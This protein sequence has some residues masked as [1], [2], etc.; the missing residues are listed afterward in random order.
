MIYSPTICD[1]RLTKFGLPAIKDLYPIPD[2]GQEGSCSWKAIIQLNLI[3]NVLTVLNVL[4][5]EATTACPPSSIALPLLSDHVL[6]PSNGSHGVS[7][8]DTAQISGLNTTATAPSTSSSSQT[9]FHCALRLRLAPLA[10]FESNFAKQLTQS[11]LALGT[12]GE[13]MIKSYTAWTKHYGDKSASRNAST[14]GQH[15]EEEIGRVVRSF[16]EDI[17]ALWNDKVVRELLLERN[18]K[19]SL[20]GESFLDDLDRVCVTDYEPSDCKFKSFGIPTLCATFCSSKIWTRRARH[21]DLELVSI[22]SSADVRK[23]K[24]KTTGVSETNF[25][26]TPEWIATGNWKV[27]T[28]HGSRTLRSAWV[29][30]FDDGAFIC[31]LWFGLCT[32]TLCQ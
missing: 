10:E 20:E 8:R 29:P 9:A 32:F 7:A 22:L 25:C 28:M 18:V 30:F 23:V 6:G 21:A 27:Y 31:G 1:S 13:P 16:K 14:D 19:F 2:L 5:E 4:E 26:V 24:R 12:F 17:A 15:F 11:P 3:Q